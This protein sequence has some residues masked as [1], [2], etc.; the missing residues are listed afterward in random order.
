MGLWVLGFGL[1]LVRNWERVASGSWL[2]RIGEVFVSGRRGL[3]GRGFVCEDGFRHECGGWECCHKGCAVL[4]D[5]CDQLPQGSSAFTGLSHFSRRV[6]IRRRNL[7]PCCCLSA[8]K[9][10]LCVHRFVFRCGLACASI[11]VANLLWWDYKI[12]PG[13][14]VR[15]M[16]MGMLLNFASVS[17]TIFCSVV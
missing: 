4:E 13:H 6:R 16:N 7:L 9:T 12:C 8:P 11:W 15:E 3:L 10:V 14:V 1:W 2:W 5:G 17:Y